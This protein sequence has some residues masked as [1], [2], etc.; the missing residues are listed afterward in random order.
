MCAKRQKAVRERGTALSHVGEAHVLRFFIQVS[1]F[2]GLLGFGT[3]QQGYFK[4]H[5]I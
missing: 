4:A 2:S 5:K 3:Y 1:I